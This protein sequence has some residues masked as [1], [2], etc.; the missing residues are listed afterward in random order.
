MSDHRDRFDDALD[1]RLRHVFRPPVEA[2]F[3][4]LARAA[5]Q[6]PS[7]RQH[8]RWW[9]WVVAAAAALLTIGMLVL[10]P[11][12]GPEGHD[13]RELGALWAAAFAHAK[14]SGF[15]S[16]SC[17]DPQLDFGRECERRFSVR[18]GL[19]DASAL[20]LH[21][22]YCGLSTGGCVAVLAETSDGPVGVFAVPRSRDPRPVLPAGSRLHLARRELGPLVLYAVSSRANDRA[23]AQFR[24][25]P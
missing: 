2:Q 13:G 22:C 10:R 5:T 17:C 12:R 7:W 20:K 25:E 16:G 9:P 21:G 18:L 3:A 1:A 11:S 19:D 6:A 15:G 8:R 4:D 14:A 24:V 23:L